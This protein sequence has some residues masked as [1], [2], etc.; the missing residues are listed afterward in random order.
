MKEVDL[1][2]VVVGAE[3]EEVV[4]ALDEGALENGPLPTEEGDD[5]E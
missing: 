4:D 3:G 2:E 5:H 1:Q